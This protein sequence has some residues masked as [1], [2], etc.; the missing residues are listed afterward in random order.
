[1][2]QKIDYVL[3]MHKR[4]EGEVVKALPRYHQIIN[5]FQTLIENGKIH[6]GSQMPTEQEIGQLFGVS[7]NTV[8]QA[9]DGLV[10]SGYVY[11]IQG[12]GTFVSYRKADMQ[13][14]HLSGFSE[15]MRAQGMEPSTVLVEITHMLP[16]E[17]VAEMLQ[18]D[19][20][21]QIYYMVRLRCADGVPMA[22]E[23]VHVPF[24]RFVGLENHDLSGS[25]YALLKDEYG[26]ECARGT[27]NIRAGAATAEDAKLLNIPVGFPVLCISRTTYSSDGVPFEYVS[28]VYR[29]DRYVF[30][31]TLDK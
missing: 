17:F 2:K 7:R 30:N 12:K 26:C 5:Y 27:Q 28:S 23:K 8:R 14:N 16:S 1:M 15:E 21:Q 13:L 20:L 25:M 9:L 31:V 4:Q 10:Q 24:H 22:V 29:G 11:K 6:E 3:L 19:V 18:I